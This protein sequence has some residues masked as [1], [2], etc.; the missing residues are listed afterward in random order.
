MA[1]TVILNKLLDELNTLSGQFD[2]VFKV[3]KPL[4][5]FTFAETPEGVTPVKYRNDV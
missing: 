5:H 4:Y 1:D 2:S 3:L